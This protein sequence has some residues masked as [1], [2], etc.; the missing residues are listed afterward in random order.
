[1]SGWLITGLQKKEKEEG[2]ET[3]KKKTETTKY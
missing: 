3:E 2:Q 1:M